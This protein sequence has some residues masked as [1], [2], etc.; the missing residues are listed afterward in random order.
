MSTF[1]WP[2]AAG[3]AQMQWGVLKSGVQFAS[4][5]NGTMQALNFVAD[6]FVVSVT[7][8]A[9]RLKDASYGGFFSRLAGGEHRVRLHYMARPAPLGTMRGS[10]VVNTTAVRG[11]SSIVLLTTP[12]ATLEPDDM[13]KVSTQLFQ[14]ADRC[15]ANG[16]GVLTV[17]L[18]CRVRSTLVNGLSVTWSRPTGEFIMPATSNRIGFVP[19]SRAPSQFDLQEIWDA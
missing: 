3:V 4:P 12:G 5:M 18:V 1:D 6:R 11:N 19:G 17:P 7:T 16:S 15:V 2:L 9:A 14:V 10:P 8:P 13:F